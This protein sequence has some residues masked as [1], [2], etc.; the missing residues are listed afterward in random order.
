[1]VLVDQ[2]T[3]DLAPRRSL[4]P[5]WA[6]GWDRTD[7]FV[8]ATKTEPTMRSMRVVVRDVL[9]QDAHQVSSAHDQHVIEDL[10]PHA[11]DQSLDVT[12]GLR[13]PV[14]G[15]HDLDAFGA[16]DRIEAAAVLRVAVAEQEARAGL[17]IIVKIHHQVAAP[18]G[19]G[20]G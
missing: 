13:G 17:E 18:R 11:S 6:C 3:D 12:V 20:L 2:P 4:G 7:D 14:R 16:E 19:S 15:E 10:P 5:R 8:R 9:T 1:M